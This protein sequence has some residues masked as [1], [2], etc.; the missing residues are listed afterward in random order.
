MPVEST[1]GKGENTMIRFVEA[2]R[3]IREKPGKYPGTEYVSS[4]ID[5]LCQESGIQAD[6]EWWEFTNGVIESVVEEAHQL[7]GK[8]SFHPDF[9]GSETFKQWEKSHFG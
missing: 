5:Q 1:L 6:D 3:D 7:Y 2:L 4:R 8:S 9:T